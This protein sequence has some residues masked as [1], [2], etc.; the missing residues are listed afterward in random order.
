MT[1]IL[2][3]DLE[4]S[5]NLG[6]V[7]Q[8]WQQDVIA[9]KE[10]WE[11]LSFAYK[12]HGAKK[13]IAVGQDTFSE[14]ILVRRLWQLFDEADVLVAHNANKFDVKKANAKF[15]QYGLMPP[16]PYKVIDTLQ[17]AKRY[18]KFN[19]NKLDDLGN[20]LGVGRKVETGGFSLWLGCMNND[21]K[22]WAKMLRYNKQDVLLLE[23][24]YLKLRPWM[25]NH[26]ALNLLSDKPDAC[27]KCEVSGKMQAR[28]WANTKVARRRR[29]QCQACGGWSQGRYS[30]RTEVQ[31]VN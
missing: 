15:I 4:T 18:F 25:D 20:L 24:V 30:E 26:P 5:P 21:P 23:K 7:W 31:F 1:K 17:I 2:H 27:P 28:G 12:W 6:W 22:S 16:A 9:F 8:K 3:F 29:Y 11:L 14:E 10:E 19:S 13:T